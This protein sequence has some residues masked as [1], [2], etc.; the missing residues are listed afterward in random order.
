MGIYPII[1]K[2]RKLKTA[3]KARKSGILFNQNTALKY[4]IVSGIFDI[5]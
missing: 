2:L 4:V 1:F 5:T 3:V